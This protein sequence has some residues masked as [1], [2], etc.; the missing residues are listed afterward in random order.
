MGIIEDIEAIGKEGVKLFNDDLLKICFNEYM[1]RW[2]NNHR[3]EWNKI[4]RA[5]YKKHSNN[6]T[7]GENK[8]SN[9][10]TKRENGHSN[11]ITNDKKV[12]GNNIT[13]ANPLNMLSGRAL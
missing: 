11:I 8:S 5:N 1:R 4:R 12:D 9:I 13:K 10:I 6:I 7:K 3:D 2:R